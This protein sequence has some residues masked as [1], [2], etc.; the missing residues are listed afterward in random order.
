MSFH[1]KLQSSLKR[2]EGHIHARGGMN[3]V[4]LSVYIWGVGPLKLNKLTLD[5]FFCGLKGQRLL[6]DKLKGAFSDVLIPSSS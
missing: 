6:L 1:D 3:G 4:S 5:S 2:L